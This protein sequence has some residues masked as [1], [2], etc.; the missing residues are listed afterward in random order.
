VKAH[1]TF[2][3][4]PELRKGSHARRD[5]GSTFWWLILDCDPELGRYLR[6]LYLIGHRR[7]RSLQPP[8]WGTHISIIRGEKPPKPEW[9]NHRNGELV[10]F[11]YEPII[12]ETDAYLWFQVSCPMAHDVREELGLPRDIVPPLHLTIGNALHV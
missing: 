11:E 5:G 2:R 1:G 10:E 7:T 9:W 12:R 6:H 3:Y 8:L 4:S